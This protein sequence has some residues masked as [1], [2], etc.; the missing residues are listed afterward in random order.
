[1][2]D[3]KLSSDIIIIFFRND[4][5]SVFPLLVDYELSMPSV[6]SMLNLGS[7]KIVNKFPNTT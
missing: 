6:N 5:Y 2:V 4:I 7:W 1:M 3:E